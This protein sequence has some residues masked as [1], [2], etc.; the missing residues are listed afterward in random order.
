MVYRCSTCRS[1]EKPNA[2]KRPNKV[3]IQ[4]WEQ[5]RPVGLRRAAA[6]LAADRIALDAHMRNEMQ[7]LRVMEVNNIVNRF[8]AALTPA[9]LMAGFSMVG[10]SAF[11]TEDPDNVVGHPAHEAEPVFYL[12]ATLSLASCLYVTTIATVGIVFGQRLTIQ[13]TAEQGRDHDKT[14]K[15]L[16]VKFRSTLVALGC[17]IFFTVIAGI[18]AVWIKDP[19][20][21]ALAALATNLTIAGVLKEDPK[22]AGN[23]YVSWCA[24]A[25][26]SAVL[27]FTAFSIYQMYRRLHVPSPE[28]SSLKVRLNGG[29]AVFGGLPEFYLKAAE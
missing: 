25:I 28:N 20:S 6:M 18:A 26:A 27:C 10:I 29:K 16:T 22:L 19:S 7:H 14:V 11:E 1:L 15:E 24:T 8:Q 23:G 13:A 2:D 17:S 4:A 3:G 9:T 21:A 12:C 5:W